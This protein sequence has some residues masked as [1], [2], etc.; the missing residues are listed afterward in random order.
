MEIDTIQP[1]QSNESIFY[2]DTC[3]PLVDAWQRSKVKFKALARYTYP[4][5]RLTEDTLGLNTVG[6]WDALGSQ[7]WGLDWHRNEGIEVH[8]L[9]SGNMPYSLENIDL[10][11][12]ANDL[13]ITRPWQAH[14]VGNP[15]VGIGKF[16]WV[17]LD[18]GVRQ[19]HQEWIW[20]EWMILSKK[21]LTRLTQIL[22]QNEQPFWK[23]NAAIRNCF[24]KIGKAIETDEEGSNA[25]KIKLYINELFILLLELFEEGP[26]ELDKALTDS[27][28]SV[29]FFRKELALR[30]QEA[31]TVELMAKE[32]GLGLTRFIHYFK[33]LTNT[34]P[35]Q[36]LNMKRLEIAKRMLEEKKRYSITDIAYHCGFNT[37][38]YFATLFKKHEKCSPQ[39]YKSRI[40][41]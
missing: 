15:V 12:V 19:P 14:R 31:W 32:A 11:L 37:S 39:D 21:D 29:N 20:P 5:N 7:D 9:E 6:Y 2:A 36:Y 34:T 3:L 40:N 13:T 27:L 17:I 26:I 25:S 22:R 23:S 41:L 10:D 1:F 8:F 38:Q 24:Q 18:V 35:M 4:G 33:Q 16:Y 30:Y 28:R